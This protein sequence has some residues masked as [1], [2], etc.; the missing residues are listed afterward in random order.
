MMK[1]VKEGTRHEDESGNGKEAFIAT[2]LAHISTC[3]IN[4]MNQTFMSLSKN[5]CVDPNPSLIV[6][7]DRIL[8]KLHSREWDE[9]PYKSSLALSFRH[10]RPEQQDH[11]L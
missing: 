4:A 3:S 2:S 8:G 9:C 6:L 5:S 7:E 10:V 11:H 1:S